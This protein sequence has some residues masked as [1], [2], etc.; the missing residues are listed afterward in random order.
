MAGPNP[1]L[2]LGTLNRLRGTV[3]IPLRPQLNLT[4]AQLGREGIRLAVEGNI[5]DMIQQMAGQVQSPNVY[6]P[7]TLTVALI[8]TQPLANLY[9]RQYESDSNLGKVTFRSDAKELDPFEFENCAIEGVEGVDASGQSALFGVRI[10]G[11]YF[12]NSNMWNL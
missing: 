8:K 10:S 4:A 11:T 1:L 6:L 7:A 9:K 12:I 3:I 5:T 2:S